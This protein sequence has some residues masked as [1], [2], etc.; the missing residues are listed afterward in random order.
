MLL[1]TS[2]SQSSFSTKK[3]MAVTLNRTGNGHTNTGYADTKQKKVITVVSHLHKYTPINTCTWIILPTQLILCVF[4]WS[5]WGQRPILYVYF[6][7]W[8]G[9]DFSF[10]HKVLFDHIWTFA[11]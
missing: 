2:F 5:V 4:N 3:S 8:L 11:T 7:L 1:S 6:V 10:S 9:F